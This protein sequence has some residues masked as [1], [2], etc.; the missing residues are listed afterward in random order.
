[1]Y[2]IIC[3]KR[4]G[5]H[6]IAFPSTKLR[7]A[8]RAQQTRKEIKI[9]ISKEMEIECWVFPIIE[10]FINYHLPAPCLHL[11]GCHWIHSQ[12]RKCLSYWKL[13]LEVERGSNTWIKRQ[14]NE[15]SCL[16]TSRYDG[17][18]EWLKAAEISP[19]TIH[20]TKISDKTPNNP[21][22]VFCLAELIGILCI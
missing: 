13:G 9:E 17:Q 22:A 11:C 8:Q 1:M 10:S 19:W 21:K 4:I 14:H 6:I 18:Q 7:P 2:K 15:K 12:I 3:L 20:A 5:I 16:I